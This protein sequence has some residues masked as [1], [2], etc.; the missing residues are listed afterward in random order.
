MATSCESV[1]GTASPS[2]EDAA[3]FIRLVY[4]AMIGVTKRNVVF[5][6]GEPGT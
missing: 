5:A 1:S 4:Q 6:H 3:D 2:V